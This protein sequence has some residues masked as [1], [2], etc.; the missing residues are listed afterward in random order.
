V[1]ITNICAFGPADLQPDQVFYQIWQP[2]LAH[3]HILCFIIKKNKSR[4]LELLL[5]MQRCF[6]E[7]HL[8]IIWKF[9]QNKICSLFTFMQVMRPKWSMFKDWIVALIIKQMMVYSKM[10]RCYS[11]IYSIDHIIQTTCKKKNFELATWYI[12]QISL[13]HRYYR[14]T[15]IRHS[16]LHLEPFFGKLYQICLDFVSSMKSKNQRNV[17]GYLNLVSRLFLW[18]FVQKLFL[19]ITRFDCS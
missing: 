15:N 18:S 6:E 8:V 12:F 9:F 3:R 7:F 13:Y 10:I 19:I 14:Y 2:V 17:L 1:P 16:S 11:I 4:T 5:Y